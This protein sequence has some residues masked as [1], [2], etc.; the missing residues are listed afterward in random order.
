MTHTPTPAP[1]STS[2]KPAKSKMA[3]HRLL[4]YFLLVG[5]N[6]GVTVGIVTGATGLGVNYLIA[7][8][9]VALFIAAFNYV[10]YRK[11]I[12]G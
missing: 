2:N 3:R 6:A 4:R 12:Y 7:K 9:I 1:A 11:W 5:L 8:A 10:A